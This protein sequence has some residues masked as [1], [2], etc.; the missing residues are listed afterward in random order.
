MNDAR[1]RAKKIK[2]RTYYRK[3]YLYRK[4]EEKEL[5]KYVNIT[6][7][8]M[9]K[10]KLVLANY[11]ARISKIDIKP[12]NTDTR[13]DLNVFYRP[14]WSKVWEIVCYRTYGSHWQRQG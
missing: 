13:N 10:A 14:Y 12:K 6:E 7:R 4:I 8:K 5:I 3:E 2:D 9:K 1:K 11:D